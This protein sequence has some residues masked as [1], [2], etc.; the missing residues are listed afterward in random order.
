MFK[1]QAHEGITHLESDDR[2]I[3]EWEQMWETVES[4]FPEPY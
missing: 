2:R 3:F 1:Q 4:T